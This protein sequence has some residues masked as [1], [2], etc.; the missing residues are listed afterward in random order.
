VPTL[1]P[2]RVLMRVPNWIGDAAMAT[3]V[4]QAFAEQLPQAHL[5]VVGRGAVTDL[6]PGLLPAERCHRMAPGLRAALRG[7]FDLG[8]LLPD[9]FSS[10][11]FFLRA[12][13]PALG[14]RADAR[15]LLLR[16][17]RP[18]RPRPPRQHVLEEWDE[19]L[20]PLG[21]TPSRFVPRIRL[22]DAERA[23]GVD[24]ISAAAQTVRGPGTGVGS[25]QPTNPGP[26][27]R[28]LD[29]TNPGPGPRAVDPTNPGPDP[30]ADHPAAKP[31][32]VPT[33]APVAVLAPGAAY[34]S[35]KRWPVDRFTALAEGLRAAG[36]T[37]LAAGA[38]G[39]AA[40]VQPVAQAAGTEALLGL[41]VRPWAACLAAADLVVTND[42]GA[43]HVAAAC[44]TPVLALFGS[45]SPAWTRPRGPG[46]RVLSL[47]LP[48][49]PCFG[50]ECRL[51]HL[52]CLLKMPVGQVLGAALE[53]LGARGEP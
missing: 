30:R 31:A 25:A 50:R 52:D 47:G 10:A 18:P 40:S 20:A 41:Q 44:G 21:L 6:F 24:R 46:H 38:A 32:R 48:C 4:V 13:I 27:P 1:R 45:T 29:P 15:S 35:A 36:V 53:M 43:S 16:H 34:G 2:R 14:R 17:R 28:A 39:E 9:S 19:L 5:E 33:R 42:S 7:R 12:G 8:V 37:C 22:D 49:A 26:G 3:S 23:A 11:W 51:G